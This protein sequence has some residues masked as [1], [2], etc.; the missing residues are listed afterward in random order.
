MIFGYKSVRGGL[1]GPWSVR[2]HVQKNCVPDK[3]RKTPPEPSAS[4]VKTKNSPQVIVAPEH[5][6]LA[7]VPP[8]APAPSLLSKS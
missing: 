8:P 2:R 5:D 4:S 3:R 7:P 1:E 6:A